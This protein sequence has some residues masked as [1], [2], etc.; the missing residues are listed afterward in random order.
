MYGAREHACMLK[1]V[2]A[3]LAA[4]RSALK[5]PLVVVLCVVSFIAF[6]MPVLRLV[7]LNMVSGLYG[8]VHLI[9][10]HV[11]RKKKWRWGGLPYQM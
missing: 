5:T 9:C 6:F 2:P 8:I 3:V 10:G 4:C 11:R 1:S 7:I